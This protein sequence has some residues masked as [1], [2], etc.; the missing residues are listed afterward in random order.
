MENQKAM[1]VTPFSSYLVLHI[2]DL[3]IKHAYFFKQLPN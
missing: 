3:I 1:L 2:D